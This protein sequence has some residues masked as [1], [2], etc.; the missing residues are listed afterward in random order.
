[1]DR[2]IDD[3]STLAIEDCLISKLSTL[4]RSKNVMNMSSDDITRLAEETPE[5]STER[6]RLKGKRETLETGL[7][8]L[9]SLY[10]RRNINNRPQQ[11][12]VTSDDSEETPVLI[13]SRSEKSSTATSDSEKAP[14]ASIHDEPPHSPDGVSVPSSSGEW[15]P[16]VGFQD[17]EEGARRFVLLRDGRPSMNGTVEDQGLDDLV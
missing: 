10:K 1:M 13:T 8:N 9:K 7:Q 15:S 17:G 6:S 11:N 16:Q 14:R 2:F 4:F 12:H 3:V 5:S